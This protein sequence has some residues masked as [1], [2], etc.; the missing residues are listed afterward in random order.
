[1]GW[2]KTLDH[3]GTNSVILM[4][5]DQ[6]FEQQTFLSECIKSDS[7]DC[8]VQCTATGLTFFFP[9]KVP[10]WLLD[11]PALGSLLL[12]FLLEVEINFLLC[13]VRINQQIQEKKGK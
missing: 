5:L 4:Q 6:D 1:M 11:W 13:C 10:D 2:L 9:V 8:A 3:F 7:D 12:Y